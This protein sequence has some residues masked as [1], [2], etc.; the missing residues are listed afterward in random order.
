MSGWPRRSPSA[1]K[2]SST[3]TS[4]TRASRTTRLHE[5]LAAQTKR[6]ARASGVLRL[7]DHRRGRGRADEWHR[8]AAA[9]RREADVDGPALGHRLQ[10]RARPGRR[11]DRV[12]PDVLGRAAR[13]RPAAGRRGRAQGDRHQRLRPGLRRSARFGDRS[14]DRKGLGPRRDQGRRRD[15]RSRTRTR[16]TTSPRRRWRRRSCRS[17]PERRARS[18]SLSPSWPSR[19]R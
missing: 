17:S 11:A 3:R 12:C 19:T 4:T 10:D 2:R 15:R 6:G 5:E 9:R 7:G 14:P 8:G 13:A 1:T 16:S 18:T